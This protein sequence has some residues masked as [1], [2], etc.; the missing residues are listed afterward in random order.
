VEDERLIT[1]ETLNYQGMSV[2]KKA[3]EDYKKIERQ[4]LKST[5]A[6]Q[7]NL[8]VDE[9]KRAEKTS[10]VEHR[11]TIKGYKK[12]KKAA[13]TAVEKAWA[14]YEQAEE[15]SN[16]MIDAIKAHQEP[17]PSDSEQESEYE[18]GE[19]TR[20]WVITSHEI[21]NN[22]PIL[23]LDNHD[24][25]CEDRKFWGPPLKL[26]KDGLGPQVM[27]Y[28]QE[29]C[30]YGRWL[31]IFQ[32]LQGTYKP[33]KRK[34]APTEEATMKEKE[35]EQQT[36]AICRHDEFEDDITYT[37]EMNAGFCKKGSY[38][39]GLK[40]GGGG[41][42]VEFV[43]N[44]NEKG[45]RPDQKNPIYCCIFIDG[46]RANNRSGGEV[47]KHALCAACWVKGVGAAAT[48]GGARKRSRRSAG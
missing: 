3:A 42:A 28:I 33:K 43:A 38:L 40:C 16:N 19:D 48:G 10:S 25:R 6:I 4:M 23:W 20:L 47:C 35:M 8:L 9:E 46:R 36:S 44:K 29:N 32:K 26:A 22:V 18:P 15:A 13:K 41:C 21:E 7:E 31:T 17:A 1:A 45:F 37:A 11:A 39:F 27:A 30:F 14:V 34:Q 12:K 2:D 24:E 5:R